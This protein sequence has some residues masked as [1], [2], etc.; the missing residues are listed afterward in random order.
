MSLA[1]WEQD[2]TLEDASR[3]TA[4][5]HSSELKFALYHHAMNTA[6]GREENAASLVEW[7]PRHSEGRVC[8]YLAVEIWRKKLF[9]FWMIVWSTEI[10]LKEF[11]AFLAAPES[12]L[13][14][15]LVC[16]EFALKTL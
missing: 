10:G 7:G 14:K 3:D 6:S 9:A 16:K 11:A 4:I 8:Q 13:I 15:G 5:K 12:E 1:A 2:T